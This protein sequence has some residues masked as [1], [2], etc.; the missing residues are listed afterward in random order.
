MGISGFN[1]NPTHYVD[2]TNTFEIKKKAISQHKSQ[3]DFLSKLFKQDF[4]EVIELQARF[5]GIQ[6]GVKYAEAYTECSVYHRIKSYR[7]LP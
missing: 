2:I 7:V 5:R 4:L 3:L 6:C 1:T